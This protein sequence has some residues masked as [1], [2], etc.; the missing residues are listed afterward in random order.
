[1]LA[2]RSPPFL[3]E[4]VAGVLLET[5]WVWWIVAG[6]VGLGICWMSRVRSDRRSMRV[7]YAILGVAVMWVLAALLV[8]T[9]RERLTRIH[10]ELGAAARDHDFDR[11]ASFLADDFAAPQIGVSGDAIP[12]DEIAARI[13]EYGVKESYFRALSIRMNGREADSAITLLTTTDAGP[14]L[15]SWELRW[16]DVPGQDWQIR[17]ARLTRLGDDVVPEGM[18]LK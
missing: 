14:I 4:G 3:P 15:T 7:G 12:R 18:A 13:K 1:M 17:R 6:V 10:E 2:L 5:H 16:R 11:V 8:D 9:P